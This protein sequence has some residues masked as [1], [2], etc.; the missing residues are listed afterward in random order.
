MINCKFQ[1]RTD[2]ERVSHELTQAVERHF[3]SVTIIII[4]QLAWCVQFWRCLM[5]CLRE[6]VTV[7]FATLSYCPSLGPALSI[8]SFYSFASVHKTFAW[9]FSLPKPYSPS[10]SRR[11]ETYPTGFPSQSFTIDGLFVG[12]ICC[13]HRQLSCRFLTP[14]V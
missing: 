3:G 1:S 12:F 11:V 7:N 2:C 8:A 13:T 9:S 5:T 4:V 14:M 6:D 10:R